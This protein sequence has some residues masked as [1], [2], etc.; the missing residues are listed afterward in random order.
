VLQ[1]MQQPP[2][3]KCGAMVQRLVLQEPSRSSRL[4]MQ[5][6]QQP[7]AAGAAAGAADAARHACMYVVWHV[8]KC[9]EHAPAVTT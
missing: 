4:A 6:M 2:A 3:C 9:L 1:Q 7:P 8:I 5:Y